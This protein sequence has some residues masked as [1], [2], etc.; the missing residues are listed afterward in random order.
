[1]HSVCAY[2]IE[3]TFYLILKISMPPWSFILW[4]N[5]YVLIDI[6]TGVDLTCISFCSLFF[7]V[8]KIHYS[9]C[10]LI[11]LFSWFSLCFT[12]DLAIIIYIEKHKLWE[13][14]N[15]LINTPSL[16]NVRCLSFFLPRKPNFLASN[17]VCWK[18]YSCL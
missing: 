1:M 6:F 10:S 14:K 17:Q 12:N 8:Q 2:E 3:D 9:S 13:W 16:L 11:S 18:T 7:V 15:T 5:H 4:H